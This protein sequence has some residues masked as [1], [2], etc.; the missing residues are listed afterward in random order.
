[1]RKKRLVYPNEF[2]VLN[3]TTHHKNISSNRPARQMS[4]DIII[5]YQLWY[6]IIVYLA[7]TRDR[8]DRI[9]KAGH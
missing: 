2:D 5:L 1:M 9:S 4:I 3:D 6:I 7:R 8:H